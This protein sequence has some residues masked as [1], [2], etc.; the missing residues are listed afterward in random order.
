MRYED[1]PQQTPHGF[2]QCF[3]TIYHIPIEAINFKHKS[4]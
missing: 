4:T 2:G 1:D 3:S